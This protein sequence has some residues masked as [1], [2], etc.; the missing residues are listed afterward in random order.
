MMGRVLLAIFSQNKKSITTKQI[1]DDVRILRKS[2]T[3][4]FQVV[5]SR[6]PNF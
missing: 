4:I 3:L 2:L 1:L 5:D 6:Y